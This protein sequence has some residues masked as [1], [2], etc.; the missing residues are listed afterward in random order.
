MS[1]RESEACKGQQQ[2]QQH[3]N[4]LLQQLRWLLLLLPLSY[5]LS[6]GSRVHMYLFFLA[7]M[8]GTSCG[9]HARKKVPELPLSPARGRSCMD[10]D[11]GGLHQRHLP[12]IRL[13]M[14]NIL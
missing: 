5:R 9:F 12:E 13:I 6:K 4:K 1:E 3:P 14:K 10:S 7:A 8:A 11:S 2:Q